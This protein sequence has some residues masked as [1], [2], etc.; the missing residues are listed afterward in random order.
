MLLN[1]L[2]ATLTE[3]GID[4]KIVFI[5]YTDTY[6]APETVR[7]NHPERFI[8][9]TATTGR[10][11][12]LP[13]LTDRHD[14]PL[15]EYRRNRNTFTVTM[16]LSLSFTDSWKPVFDGKRFLFEYHFWLD[17]YVDPGY[18]HFTKNIYNDARSIAD[19]GFHGI[20]DDKTQRSY[21]PTGLPM[22]IYGETLFDRELDLEEYTARYFEKCFGKDAKKARAYLEE[23][24]AIFDPD[25]LRVSDD[26]VVVDTGTGGGLKQQGFIGNP[27]TVERISKIYDCLE[28]FH[29]IIEN[30]RA[31][32]AECVQESWRILNL[33]QEYC[34]MYAEVFIA[35]GKADKSLATEK[36]DVL[37]DWLGKNEDK[38]QPYLDLVLFIQKL[39]RMVK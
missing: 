33:H 32:E 15:P 31:E 2:D 6:W 5:M 27:D 23:I 17:H 3:K 9:T 29:P 11:R 28:E 10:D 37:K 16:P 34:R 39:D 25:K 21:F 7:F 4:T 22:A 8:M 12:S 13:Y 20:M 1:E 18:M 14:G 19:A 36:V 30:D 35:L 26:V 38:F 24:S